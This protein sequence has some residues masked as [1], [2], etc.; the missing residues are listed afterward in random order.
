MSTRSRIAM[1]T[2]QGGFR[3]VYCHNSGSLKGPCGVGYTLLTHYKER[4][5]VEQLME[6]G[7]LSVLGPEIGRKHNGTKRMSDLAAMERYANWCLAYR[8]DRGDPD[9]DAEEH[10]V[11]EELVQAAEDSDAEY[12]YMLFDEVWLYAEIG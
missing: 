1:T 6:L 3:S 2:A 5:K 8:R 12:L 4:E 11:F 7:H 9:V 10:A